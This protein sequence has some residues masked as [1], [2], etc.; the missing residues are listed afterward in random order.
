[1]NINT[2]FKTIIDEIKRLNAPTPILNEFQDFFTA[3][4]NLSN[5]NIDIDFLYQS[6]YD[7]LKRINEKYVEDI[8]HILISKNEN[9]EHVSEE[10]ETSR[11]EHIQSLNQIDVDYMKQ[12]KDIEKKYQDEKQQLL[13]DIKSYENEKN[14]QDTSIL[15][16]IQ[17][18]KKQYE[19]RVV[20]IE[21]TTTL[22]IENVKHRFED[23]IK[24]IQETIIELQN[25]YEE[26]N[27]VLVQQRSKESTSH[28]TD[29]ID[30]KSHYNILNITL[31]KQINQLK[32]KKAQVLSDL[33]KIYD[34]RIQPIDA[35]VVHFSEKSKSLKKERLQLREKEIQQLQERKR[36]EIERYE[37]SK[38]KIIAQTAEAVSLLNSKLSNFRELTN[39]KKRQ[40]VRDFQTQSMSSN[41]ETLQKNRKLTYHD[42]ELNQFILKIRKDIKQKK[43]EGQL[44][45]FE[46]QKNHQI[47]VADIEFL[48]KKE[49]YQTSYDVKQIELYL[50]HDHDKL[51]DQKQRLIQ[52]KLHYQEMIESAYLKD[53]FA[54]ETQ[55]NL[56]SQTQ[57]RDLGQLVLDA[58]I[59][60]AQLDK[61]ILEVQSKHDQVILKHQH[62]I[63]M[64]Q[65]HLD[66]ELIKLQN[67]KS[68]HLD[69]TSRTRDLDL[70]ESQLRL[71][72]K[73]ETFDEQTAAFKNKLETLF[74]IYEKDLYHHEYRYEY[75]KETLK[76]THDFKTT[77]R[78][79][80]VN[81][82]DNRATLT[83]FQMDFYRSEQI[84]DTHVN[85]FYKLIQNIMATHFE[86]TSLLMSCTQLLEQTFQYHE[87]P[88]TMRQMIEV[89]HA[90][91]LIIS[92][93]QKNLSQGLKDDL[94]RTYE[95][96]F[97]N[98]KKVVLNMRQKD[99]TILNSQYIANLQQ[100]KT[101]FIKKK[102]EYEV[103]MKQSSTLK[104][105][106][107]LKR[108]EKSYAQTNA[109]ILALEQKI[110]EST[111]EAHNHFDQ[112]RAKFNRFIQ[113]K[114][115]HHYKMIK[116]LNKSEQFTNDF[117]SATLSQSQKLTQTLYYTHQVIFGMTKQTRKYY[118]KLIDTQQHQLPK[119]YTILLE[120][121]QDMQASLIAEKQSKLSHIE[122]TIH[123]WE[124]KQI[125]L[126]SSFDQE[127]NFSRRS[128]REN[129][130]AKKNHA[131]QKISNNYR[132]FNEAKEK[133]LKSIQKLEVALQSFASKKVNTLET[134][135]LN[136]NVMLD[137]EKLRFGFQE[138]AL[139]THQL[140]AFETF[141]YNLIKKQNEYDEKMQQALNTIEQ[142]LVKYLT[143][144]EKLRT[145]FKDK[146]IDK[147]LHENKIRQTYKKRM[148]LSKQKTSKML[149]L[150]KKE[151][152]L[153]LILLDKHEKREQS[154]LNK[155]HQSIEFWV[156]KSYQFKLKSLDIH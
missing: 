6:F 41:H 45:L 22:N 64:L 4:E 1:M 120:Y 31:N 132:E 123:E 144:V 131:E 110:V 35:D 76:S 72:L 23:Q 155:K 61:N 150:H 49:I 33:N 75:Q 57:E 122:H 67:D 17:D 141:D 56:A 134:L 58:S 65:F 105:A 39:E 114:F 125:S 55:I 71:D 40:I 101:K 111:N 113:K 92:S 5:K 117:F 15:R 95:T 74:I 106:S 104:D 77:K 145:N 129:I 42:N 48:I 66:Q 2:Q 84:I 86:A 81:E 118:H 24:K 124:T 93:K 50:K 16:H 99:E 78:L 149:S 143:F 91:L 8:E 108:I 140:K 79:F 63:E 37:A 10:K 103:L 139:K 80:M 13:N 26:K 135:R 100:E 94:I 46:L 116:L 43:G 98:A 21:T 68:H 14:K 60:M 88:E 59:E 138:Q 70:E 85:Q 11:T 44:L 12:K 152:R 127:Q 25:K 9:H 62:Q 147:T 142:R 27:L 34:A 3:F 83:R 133:R 32:L 121:Q 73:Q 102:Y 151:K 154:I 115:T 89:L 146:I 126:Q 136:Q 90:S 69:Q 137:Q 112:F 53:I 148:Y 19:T 82:F 52:E 36:L 97:E 20:A 47:L 38:K 7:E 96:H 30:I 107:A 87:H 109:A 54:F 29:Y 51:Y 128:F 156:K 153:H 18:I 130:V 119:L 28:D